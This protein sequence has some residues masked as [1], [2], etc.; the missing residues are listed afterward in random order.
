[1][2]LKEYADLVRNRNTPA[3]LLRQEKVF[4]GRRFMQSR[5]QLQLLRCR[6]IKTGQM[7]FFRPGI[8]RIVTSG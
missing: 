2:K 5:A 6:D 7:T 8:H 1:M 4:R 3:V